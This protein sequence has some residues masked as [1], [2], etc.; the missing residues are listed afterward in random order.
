MCAAKHGSGPKRE[1]DI[2]LAAAA[3]H[4]CSY[5]MASNVNQEHLKTQPPDVASKPACNPTLSKVVNKEGI[6]PDLKKSNSF[7]IHKKQKE[8]SAHA[9]WLL[10][11]MENEPYVVAAHTIISIQH[12]VCNLVQCF[13]LCMHTL[14]AQVSILTWMRGQQFLFLDVGGGVW[15][16]WQREMMWT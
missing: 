14:L 10:L 11:L 2:S 9:H 13:I 7:L 12:H 6:H 1:E 4:K 15:G 3:N 5:F 16:G 8:N